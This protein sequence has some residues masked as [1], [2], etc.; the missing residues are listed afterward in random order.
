MELTQTPE[1]VFSPATA[2]DVPKSEIV[3][4]LQEMIA[5]TDGYR[6]AG[7]TSLSGAATVAVADVGRLFNCSAALT[8]SLDTTDNLIEGFQFMVFAGG[9]DVTI[10]PFN[11]QTI[12]GQASII[13]PSG[14]FARVISLGGGQLVALA[15]TL[16]TGLGSAAFVD[17][18]LLEGQ[19]PQLLSGGRLP[20]LDAINLTNLPK[21]F[22]RRA[23]A[24]ADGTLGDYT[25]S[26]PS[27]VNRFALECAGLAADTYS[28]RLG[29]QSGFVSAGYTTKIG[30]LDQTAQAV[31]DD[32]TR[33]RTF[34]NSIEF[35]IEFKLL[36]PTINLWKYAGQDNRDGLRLSTITGAVILPEAISQVSTYVDVGNV[37]SGT[38]SLWY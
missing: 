21:S 2:A 6:F 10:D 4:L 28:V 5:E 15:G 24:T 32:T 16:I 13:L 8:L 26:L 3:G 1:Q 37:G 11:T 30:T 25:F 14:S 29:T 22:D 38:I 34:A 31:T 27:G 23:F 35:N 9:G 36:D 20:A 18:G 33:V 17:V 12:N 7:L 19:V